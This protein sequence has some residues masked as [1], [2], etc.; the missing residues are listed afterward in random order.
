MSDGVS[1]RA[2]VEDA[3]LELVHKHS[4][5]E[6]EDTLVARGVSP[7]AVAARLA[8]SERVCARVLRTERHRISGPFPSWASRQLHGAAL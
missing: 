2:L 5:D 7:Q 6:I 1:L 8:D 3:A 4:L